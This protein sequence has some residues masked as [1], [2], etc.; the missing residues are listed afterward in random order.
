MLKVTSGLIGL[1]KNKQSK[2]G[3]KSKTEQSVKLWRQILRSFL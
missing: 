1:P 3:S 2:N